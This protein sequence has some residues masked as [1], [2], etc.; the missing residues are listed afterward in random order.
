MKKVLSENITQKIINKQI[1][2]QRSSPTPAPAPAFSFPP[3]SPAPAPTFPA[4]PAPA[5]VPASPA[6]PASPAPKSVISSFQQIQ[7]GNFIN[8]WLS[9]VQ[10]SPTSSVQIGAKKSH[11]HS[12][13]DLEQ[14]QDK[15]QEEIKIIYGLEHRQEHR[16]EYKNIVDTL[17]IKPKNFIFI[18]LSVIV[19]ILVLLLP[20]MFIYDGA[21]IISI[22]RQ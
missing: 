2:N 21:N 10:K 3:A 15:K 11:T 13:Q 7:L 1:L 14:E 20:H 8:H 4:P 16:Q 12:K 6:S 22:S 17:I 9:M 5:P 18:I 19:I